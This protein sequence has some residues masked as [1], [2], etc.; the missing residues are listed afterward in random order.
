MPETNSSVWYTVSKHAT[1]EKNLSKSR[2]HC[3]YKK[4][5][6]CDTSIVA[7]QTPQAAENEEGHG[8]DQC[9]LLHAEVTA[10]K[11]QLDELRDEVKDQAKE[12]K[13]LRD[14]TWKLERFLEPG[15]YR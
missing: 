6:G 2:I 12:Q 7:L 14:Q 1:L 13:R 5:S 10:L 4:H 15:S 3:Y 8:C 11:E 9:V